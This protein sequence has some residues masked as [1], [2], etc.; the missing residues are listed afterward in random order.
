MSEVPRLRQRPG[1][2]DRLEV[3]TR[4]VANFEA[5]L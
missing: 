4:V 2:E 1:I 3:E 5:R